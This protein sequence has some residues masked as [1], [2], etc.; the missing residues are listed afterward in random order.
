MSDVVIC[1]LE[2]HDVYDGECPFWDQ[3][4]LKNIKL[5][6]KHFKELVQTKNNLW[7]HC[8]HHPL[9]KTRSFCR[10][11]QS[12]KPNTLFILRTFIWSIIIN[13]FEA[14][15]Q[16]V[17]R[18]M[19]LWNNML[20]SYIHTWNYTIHKHTWKQDTIDENTYRTHSWVLSYGPKA[21]VDLKSSSSSC[22]QRK[23]SHGVKM[24]PRKA[25]I[26]SLALLSITIQL[27]WKAL[28]EY[29]K[30]EWNL[31]WKWEKLY[32]R[33]QD[34]CCRKEKRFE[35]NGETLDTKAIEKVEILK[36][37][38]TDTFSGRRKNQLLSTMIQD[39]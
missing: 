21:L 29:W 10:L 14:Q 7:Q 36:I 23:L 31:L 37:K 32:T 19:Q 34:L 26:F 22:H 9:Y 6:L 5:K 3:A 17:Q 33:T 27:K 2:E 13:S 8:Q 28:R 25:P 16:T 4:L 1:E 30:S 18:A 12:Q 11:S 20:K 35:N 39:L 15:F 24:P 38:S